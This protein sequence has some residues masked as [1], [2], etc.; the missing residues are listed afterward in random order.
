MVS[1]RGQ[2]FG[3]FYGPA[4]QPVVNH[5]E[6]FSSLVMAHESKLPEGFGSWEVG[7]ADEIAEFLHDVLKRVR[8]GAI[9]E[10]HAVAT[11]TDYLGDLHTGYREHVGPAPSCCRAAAADPTTLAPPTTSQTRE[12]PIDQVPRAT[13]RVAET[14]EMAPLSPKHWS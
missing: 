13:A 14:T 4:L 1:S 3:P 2:L 11:L 12:L 5:L 9:G 10:A 6:R 7:R 8:S